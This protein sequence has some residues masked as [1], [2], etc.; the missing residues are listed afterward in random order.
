M[1]VDL[2]ALTDD[3]LAALA[4]R[5][6]LKRA[7]REV[8]EGKG[9][10]LA[11]SADGHVTGSFADGTVVELPPDVTI[12]DARCSCPA[13]GTCRHRVMAVLAYRELATE[14][15]SSPPS[16]V[17]PGAGETAAEPALDAPDV[18]WS[19]GSFTD[20]ELE[21]RLGRHTFGQAR[22]ALRSGYRARVRRPTHADPVAAVELAS[23]TVRFLVPE[24][25]DYAR[26]DAASG[27]REDAVA[28]AV[29]AVR[30][31]DEQQ[32]DGAVVD[33]EVGGRALAADAGSGMEPVLPVLADLLADGIT[34]TGP[35]AATTIAQAR[36]ALDARNLR[37]PVDL[38]DDLADQLE[39]YRSRRSRYDPAQA[40]AHL[41]EAIGRHRCVAG[42]GAAARVQVLGSEEAAET[43][44]R[45][46][47]LTG[48][49]ARVRGDDAS[50]TIEIYLAHPEAGVVLALRRRI[51]AG[52][53]AE[54]L[55]TAEELGRR[56]AG[57]AR[58]RDLAG[59][60]VVTESAAR[61]AN[62]TI[63]LTESRAAR[64]SVTPSAG[65][66]DHLPDGILV[67]DLE[68]E[69]ARLAGL[70]PAVVRARVVAEAVRVVAVERVDDLRYLPGAQELQA[71]IQAPRGHALLRLAHHGAA[72]GAIDALASVL[73]GADGPVRFVAG[74]L[75]RHGGGIELEPTAVAAGTTVVVPA[76]AAASGRAIASAPEVEPDRLA[77]AVADAIEITAEVLHRGHRHLPPGWSGRAAQAARHL[78]TT[79]LPAAAAAL[80]A[81][82]EVTAYGGVE[83]G[84]RWADA[85]LRLLV[86]AEQL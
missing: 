70:A 44:L 6:I 83:V 22:S 69:A 67:T 55:P 86:T 53:D 15:P 2:L 37:W 74:H 63:R 3:S 10:A 31:A 68:L 45:L 29:W 72:P 27:S 35:T 19:P 52:P 18:A 79:G 62:R 25:L 11:E 64:T 57:G 9:P 46:L 65:T 38:L 75:R 85:H 42:G 60:E 71:T 4:N 30:D 41:A 58:L 34:G 51:E 12:A 26:V 39:A 54:D 43:P 33:V 1:R 23:C 5:G 24:R 7:A 73:D 16:A 40:A 17:E 61:S 48:L 77:R 20:E 59:A 84:E 78:R 36:R 80:E 56:R 21:V 81:L 49:G 13:T 14:G 28:L 76:F 66:W 47:R 32:P 8:T 50:R 82:A